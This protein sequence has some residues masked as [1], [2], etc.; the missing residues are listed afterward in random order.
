VFECVAIIDF[1]LAQKELS[2][3][4]HSDIKPGYEEISKM[5]YAM[6]KNLE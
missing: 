4:L 1:L 3:E 6:N 5:L 2:D